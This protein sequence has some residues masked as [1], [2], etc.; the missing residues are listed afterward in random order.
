MTNKE[1][2]TVINQIIDRYTA[3]TNFNDPVNIEI[4]NDFAVAL[5]KAQYVLRKLTLMGDNLSEEYVDLLDIDFPKRDD[6]WDGYTI[7][8]H[9]CEAA[10]RAKEKKYDGSNKTDD[11]KEE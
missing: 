10:M 7:G 6:Y 9:E 2:L 4:T 11:V 8:Y 5:Y 1:A 3:L